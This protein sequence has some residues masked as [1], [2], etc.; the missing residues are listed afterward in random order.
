MV[1]RWASNR[2][3][4]GRSCI[5]VSVL[6]ANITPSSSWFTCFYGGKRGGT[7]NSTHFYGGKRGETLNSTQ[8]FGGKRCGTGWNINSTHFFERWNIKFDHHHH[9][10]PSPSPSPSPW[11][12][13]M[14]DNGL[15]LAPSHH[16]HQ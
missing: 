8:F 2:V 14:Y 1:G 3:V 6:E 12:G 4:Q 16:T 9:H 10:R 15:L 7:L 11:R 5:S 13:P